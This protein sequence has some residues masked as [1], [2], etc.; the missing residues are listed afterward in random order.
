MNRPLIAIWRVKS[1]GMAFRHLPI[2]AAHAASVRGRWNGPGRRQH[3][4]RQVKKS[5]LH[6]S[7]I[8]KKHVAQ[9]PEEIGVIGLDR[10]QMLN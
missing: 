9:S 6:S 8:R 10:E 7:Q 3:G 1:F 4:A 5:P 2:P